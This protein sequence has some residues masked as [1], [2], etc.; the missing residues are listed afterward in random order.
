MIR[1]GAAGTGTVAASGRARVWRAILALPPPDRLHEPHQHRLASLGE[2]GDEPV[3]E[4][5]QGLEHGG[6]VEVGGLKDL[7]VEAAP[8]GGDPYRPALPASGI[9]MPSGSLVSASP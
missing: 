4:V 7:E 6:V 5:D 2:F 9:V 1:A 3:G 8:A